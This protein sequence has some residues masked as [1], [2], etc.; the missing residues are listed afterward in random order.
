[1]FSNNV[2]N[3]AVFGARARFNTSLGTSSV[4]PLFPTY[5]LNFRGMTTLPSEVTFS[6]GS[7]G[8][9]FNSLGLITTAANN[10]PRFDFNPLT[11]QPIGLLLEE[12][13]TNLQTYS[14]NFSNSFYQK[15]RSSVASASGV[16]PDGTNNAFALIEDTSN[17]THS[18]DMVFTVAA[19]TTYTYSVF[20]KA[21]TGARNFRIS[22][23][24]L[25]FGGVFNFAIFDTATGN[26]ISSGGSGFTTTS[27]AIG[28]GWFR[29]SLTATSTTAGT[30]G[31]YLNAINGTSVTY[32]G[33]GT[34]QVLIYGAQLEVGAYPSSYIPTDTATVTRAA[35]NCIIT[36]LSRLGWNRNEGSLIVDLSY[37]GFST[38]TIDRIFEASVGTS[39]TTAIGLTT[40]FTTRQTNLFMN[41]VASASAPVL[42]ANTI[43]KMAVGFGQTSTSFVVNGVVIDT[44]TQAPNASIDRLTLGNRPNG[45]RQISSAC[46]RSLVYYSSRLSN[47]QLQAL[48]V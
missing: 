16:S 27:Q 22:F 29:F 26:V 48:T 14:N 40:Q 19:A 24:S 30:N 43:N 47:S 18:L 1:M 2:F 23:E 21:S 39:T 7:Q 44:I 4:F 6:R 42:T 41:G 13:R 38:N 32:T 45:D 9:Y 33:D 8:T 36:S 46:I 10:E 37:N 15:V 34:S 28:N 20:V 31:F 5:A 35:D 11:L 12:S 3:N 25:R 17:G